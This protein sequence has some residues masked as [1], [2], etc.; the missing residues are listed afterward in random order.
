MK[1]HLIHVGIMD[2][3]GTRALYLSDLLA[4]REVSVDA[5]FSVSTVDVTR[6]KQLDPSV[7]SVVPSFVDIPYQKADLMAKKYGFDRNC[8]K[9]KAFALGVFILMPIQALLSAASAVL[10]ENGL[11]GFYRAKSL[12][13]LRDCNLVV[14]SSGENF[15]EGA[16]LLPLNFFWIVSWWSMLFSRTWEILVAKYLHKLVIMFPN[17]IGPF[18]TYV[19]RFLSKLSLNNCTFVLIRDPVSYEIA[20]KM[21]LKSNRVLTADTALL[22]DSKMI[23]TSKVFFD[24]PVGVSPGIYGSTLSEEERNN[25]ILGHAKALDEGIEKHGFNVY[26][27]PHFIIGFE[28]DDLEISKLILEKMQR[29]DRAKIVLAKTVDEYKSYIDQMEI[30]ISSK[31]H[32]AILAAS[33]HVPILCIAYDHKQTGFF[34]RLGM[35]DCVINVREVTYDR[36][37]T[38]IDHVWAERGRL[39]LSLEKQIPVLQENVRRSIRNAF[40]PFCKAPLTSQENWPG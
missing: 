24:H 15:K 28:H 25:C 19:G 32:P 31:M 40:E 35:E 20:G 7:D 21:N 1:V 38:K 34:K 16:S 18:R 2:N 14:C 9:Y 11:Q 6:V 3:Q 39:K 17:S 23:A 8:Y 4:I 33:S 13:N 29:K 10:N 37:S 5:T 27:L 36:L 26:F 12:E 22:Y 30:L